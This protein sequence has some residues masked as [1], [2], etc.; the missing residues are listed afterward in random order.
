MKNFTIILPDKT[1][2]YDNFY[3]RYEENEKFPL[4]EY[5][6]FLHAVSFNGE[7]T[8]LEFKEIGT[9]KINEKV[10]EVPSKPFVFE[11]EGLIN[12]LIE[13]FL[14]ELEE[15][16]K[17]ELRKY[18]RQEIYYNVNNPFE[19]KKF[20]MADDEYQEGYTTIQPPE[21][22][23]Y[24]RFRNNEWVIDEKEKEKFDKEM[25]REEILVEIGMLETKSLRAMRAIV[26]GEETNYDIKV[27]QDY[28]DRIK[29]LRS[30]LKKY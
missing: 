5:L 11:V 13:P 14:S 26:L 9:F 16:K 4:E 21:M 6:S 19:T 22:K 15:R 27:L 28:E 24:Y 7:K 23:P 20:T 8:F 10:F 2:I 17:K 18:E 25:K 30:E 12:E 29:E 1:L 3:Y